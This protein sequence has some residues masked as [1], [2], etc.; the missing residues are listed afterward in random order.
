[1]GSAVTDCP[2]LPLP[3]GPAM[4]IWALRVLVGLADAC[5][6]VPGK[7]VAAKIRQ[8]DRVIGKRC[9]MGSLL[10]LRCSINPAIDRRHHDE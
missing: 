6:C 4:S 3:S 2:K 1:L 9:F 10:L 8:M 7:T 5:G